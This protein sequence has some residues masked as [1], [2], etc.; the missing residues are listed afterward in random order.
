MKT[1][2]PLL[3]ILLVS[4]PLI[5]LCFSILVGKN[6]GDTGFFIITTFFILSIL[7]S[8][9]AKFFFV[10]ALC[11]F[12]LH[13][14][15]SFTYYPPTISF[16]MIWAFEL[17]FFGVV[18]R[19][20]EIIR[21]DNDEFLVTDLLRSCF[22][23]I[24]EISRVGFKKSFILLS[25]RWSEKMESCSTS[26]KFSTKILSVILNN[27]FVLLF[28]LAMLVTFP[29]LMKE[30]FLYRSFYENMW[31]D[32]FLRNN[33]RQLVILSVII[34]SIYLVF[35]KVVK[36]FNWLGNKVLL[37]LMVLILWKGERLVF[38][39][40]RKYFETL[41]YIIRISPD[42]AS[43]WMNVKIIGKNFRPMPFMGK[44][45]INGSEQ[46]IKSW[47]DKTIVIEIDPIRSATGELVVRNIYAWGESESNK[48]QFTLYDSSKATME[49]E[50]RFWDSIKKHD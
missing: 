41:P 19:I 6:G 22:S 10:F 42:I 34:L 1:K 4:T 29:A 47:D 8:L 7:Y 40:S 33:L 5:Y 3:K 32:N 49:E 30:I 50:K 48:I 25:Q 39:N 2:S 27:N 24:E 26:T 45:L 36:D 28:I 15:S 14:F 9:E 38:S 37:L 18:K 13:W 21:D 44:V 12:I 17:V 11:C 23:K 35:K 16:P 43:N 46:T 31:I 20:F